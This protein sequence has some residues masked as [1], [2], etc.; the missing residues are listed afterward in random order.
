MILVSNLN[1]F[2]ASFE[3]HLSHLNFVEFL[4]KVTLKIY[5]LSLSSN[6]RIKKLKGFACCLV[7]KGMLSEN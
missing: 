6:L 5:S 4:V 7:Q 3:I 1:R 2:Q